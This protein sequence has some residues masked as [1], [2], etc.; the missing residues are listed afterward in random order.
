VLKRVPEALVIRAPLRVVTDL[1]VGVK[2]TD[3]AAANAYVVL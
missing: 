2:D 3:N 1:N